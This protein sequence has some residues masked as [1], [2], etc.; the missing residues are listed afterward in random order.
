MGF[1][2][3]RRRP[4]VGGVR[5]I[6]LARTLPAEV[7]TQ[8]PQAPQLRPRHRR[9]EHIRVISINSTTHRCPPPPPRARPALPA[10]ST[11]RRSAATPS[12]TRR[13]GASWLQIP[14]PSLGGNHHPLTAATI[15]AATTIITMLLCTQQ[16]RPTRGGPASVE[17]AVAAMHCLICRQ[18]RRQMVSTSG[19]TAM[20][21]PR[22]PSLRQSQTG[23]PRRVCKKKKNRVESLEKSIVKLS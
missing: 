10:P 14:P 17:V 11:R 2:R 20:L 3:R 13:F 19:V 23:R 7:E 15:A 1:G 12:S 4:Q 8:S 6:P 21:Q 18:R 5:C 22:A 9:G 16:Q